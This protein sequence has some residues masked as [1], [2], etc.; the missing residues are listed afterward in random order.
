MNVSGRCGGEHPEDMQTLIEQLDA[1]Q[2]LL[3]RSAHSHPALHGASRR[4]SRIAHALNRP[5][6][7]AI[8]GE[9]NSGKSTIANVL[10]GEITLPALP[11]A[12]TRL[13]TLLR[14]APAPVV[15]AVHE[16]G[17]KF[18][19]SVHDALPLGKLLRLE[20]G[21]PS[22]QLR[23][24]EILDF[25]GAAN[26]LFNADLAAIPRQGVD[27]AIWATV[28]TQAWRETERRAWSKLP[29]RLRLRGLLAVTHRDLIG[30]EDD[31]SKLKARLL[32]VQ[33][34]HFM[35]LCFAGAASRR[36]AAAPGFQHPEAA[37]L[38]VAVQRL[39]QSLEEE[40]ARKAVQLTRRVAS[41]A[42][43]SME[44]LV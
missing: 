27:A 44:R 14:H 2:R 29:R 21:L 41:R 18:A 36:E 25:P 17:R 37:D 31:F 13:P 3:Q 24:I 42:L 9:S 8:L 28:A 20:V 12:N 40:R 5:F 32:P 4:L 22:E 16:N 23:R 1:A 38:R 39:L 34:A 43:E 26:P 6:R 35:A 33:Q 7:V 19:L 30:S 15:E 10:A 11:V